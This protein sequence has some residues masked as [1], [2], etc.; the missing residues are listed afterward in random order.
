LAGLPPHSRFP[1]PLLLQIRGAYS[2]AWP[3]S[4]AVS[5]WG[6]VTPRGLLH[7]PQRKRGWCQPAIKLTAPSSF[8][9]PFPP[10]TPYSIRVEVYRLSPRGLRN[11]LKHRVPDRVA[12]YIG[13]VYTYFWRNLARNVVSVLRMAETVPHI[14]VAEGSVDEKPPG[15]GCQLH[16]QIS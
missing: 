14:Y 10:G 7:G 5:L 11:R 3:R 1:R 12:I 9:L 8:F 13:H 6:P 16:S 15:I 2:H 4:Y